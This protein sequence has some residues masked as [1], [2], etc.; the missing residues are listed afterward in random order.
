MTKAIT[1]YHAKYYAHELTKQVADNN[2]RHIFDVMVSLNPHQINAMLDV[3]I[4]W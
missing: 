3:I 2:S 4:E 1:N